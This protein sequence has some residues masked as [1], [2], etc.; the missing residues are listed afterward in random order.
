MKKVQ[1][2]SAAAI[3]AFATCNARAQ[4]QGN[5]SGDADIVVT[6]QKRSESLQKVPAAITAVTGEAL[7]NRQIANVEGLTS[8]VPGLTF[9]TYGGNARISIRG[10]G[11]DANGQG[12]EGR[13]AYY[14]N[15][16]YFSRP[17]SVASS[18]FDVDRVEVLRGPQ[19]T[20]YGRNATGGAMNVIPNA[21][22]ETMSGYAELTVGNY[23]RVSVNAAI[24]GAV[25][26]DLTARVAITG[27]RRNGYGRNV[28]TNSEIDNERSG[29]VR[30]IIKYEP[31]DI[32]SV[33]VT[34]DY[35][36]EDDRNNPLH[37]FG[38]SNPALLVP[39]RAFGGF[40]A[41]RIRDIAAKKDPTYESK[42]WGLAV[43]AELDLGFAKLRSISAYRNSDFALDSS[44]EPTN[45]SM[46]GILF[47]E[48]SKQYTQELQLSGETDNARWIVGAFYFHEA[49]TGG[50]KIPYDL[51]LL[52]NP[53]ASQVQGLT[54]QGDIKSEAIAGFGQIDYN[55]SKK[56]ELAIGMRY[57]WD[58]VSIADF[59]HVNFV[60]PYTPSYQPSSSNVRRGSKDW[61]SFLP[62]LG[63]NYQ[64][65]SDTLLYA[66]VSKGFKS[67]GFNIGD[68]A[69]AYNP[70]KL[71]SYELG[72]KTRLPGSL[73]RVNVTGFY[74][75]YSNL[76]V[77]KIISGTTRVENAASAELYGVEAEAMLKASQALSFDISASFLHSKFKEF[78]SQNPSFPTVL[79]PE[80]LAGNRLP[81]APNYT[82]VAG[83]EY[84]MDIG[85]GRLIWRGEAN[86]VGRIY[87]TPFNRLQ[88]S[89]E[90]VVKY[91]AFLKLES[92]GQD[93]NASVFIKNI[94]NETIRSS[95]LVAAARAGA[96]SLGSLQPPRTFGVTV[97]RKF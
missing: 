6:A 1:F 63:L 64:M 19:G 34:A 78:L 33:S 73:G 11:F 31:T 25:A 4:V 50:A 53:L 76:Q 71:W 85:A 81:S 69:P 75:D 62:K 28:A 83:A 68:G 12:Q 49:V 84:G 86:A 95:G 9:G 5:V 44:I 22:T 87:F 45:L 59:A 13:V 16:V 70:E 91:N 37:Y 74:Y 48:E 35:S 67:G 96:P 55:I 46:L 18:F 52:G 23:D 15:G 97:M 26:E 41:S 57:G 24:S 77:N 43:H 39:G 40:T 10:L 27:N 88:E 58:E 30:S 38:Q 32:F 8:T 79:T 60:D 21:P 3:A 20:L 72:V 29:S 17:A 65:S 61:K 42:F 90:A 66:A 2:L 89:Q 56:L 80:N 54:L 51:R 82:I 94:T 7:G 93:W 92:A 47:Y 36:R 14:S